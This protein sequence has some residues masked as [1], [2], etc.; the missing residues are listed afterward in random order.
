MKTLFLLQLQYYS[1]MEEK[2]LIEF[3]YNFQD[4]LW[5]TLQY[6]SLGKVKLIAMIFIR[7]IYWDSKYF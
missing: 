5:R 4:R 1:Y 3:V 6:I 7:D 2:S